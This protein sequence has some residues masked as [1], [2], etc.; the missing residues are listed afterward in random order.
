MAPVESIPPWNIAPEAQGFNPVIASGISSRLWYIY[1]NVWLVCLLFPIGTL[2]QSPPGPLAG[3]FALGGLA[4]FAMLYLWLMRPHPIHYAAPGRPPPP[5]LRLALLVMTLLGL[6][7]SVLYDIT[8]LWLLV[9]TSAVAGKTLRA[10]SAHLVVTVLP[11]LVLGMAVVLRGGPAGVDWMHILPLAFLV[12]ALGLDMTGLARLSGTIWELQTAREAL[13]RQAVIE[14][15][16]RLARDLHDLLGHT[17]SLIILKSE[18]AHRLMSRAPA[19]AER[20]IRDI[21]QVAR[22]TMREVR[23]AVAG[24][25]QP[26]LREELSKAQQ[27]LAAAGVQCVVEHRA[28]GLAPATDAV[29]AWAVREGITNIIR[30]SRARSCTIRV[31]R[32]AQRVVAEVIN[33][34]DPENTLMRKGSGL[35]GVAERVAALGGRI[36]AGPLQGVPGFRLWLELPVEHEIGGKAR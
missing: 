1:A 7:F 4:L 23:E 9:G 26:T 34:G 33:D 18:L 27:V 32:E 21:E 8:F 13:A 29:L 17:L 5:H 30:H 35:T 31:L 10:P 20:E 22:Q 11:L 14:E 24:Y 28:E 12:R 3:A 25:R 36:E 19:D 6:S 16:L 2:L 15:R